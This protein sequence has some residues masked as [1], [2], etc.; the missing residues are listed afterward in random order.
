MTESESHVSSRY[1]AFYQHKED[2]LTSGLA[3]WDALASGGDHNSRTH[4][5]SNHIL[6]SKMNVAIVVIAQSPSMNRTLLSTHHF[7]HALRNHLRWRTLTSI[8]DN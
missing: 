2:V 4:C 3:V 5:I 6:F 7:T 8:S 1:A